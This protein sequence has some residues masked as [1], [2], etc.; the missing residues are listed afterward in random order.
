M[1]VAHQSLPVPYSYSISYHIA[2]YFGCSRWPLTVNFGKSLMFDAKL[3][4]L[5]LF[6]E[7]TFSTLMTCLD[8]KYGK[9]TIIQIMIKNIGTIS[10]RLFIDFNI[11]YLFRIVRLVRNNTWI[12]GYVKWIT[13]SPMLIPSVTLWVHESVHEQSFW[14]L[15]IGFRHS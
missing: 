12:N 15:Y 11:L 6:T 5:W 10:R 3:S 7:T 4:N 13:L 8:F 9:Y 2:L 1:K 14:T